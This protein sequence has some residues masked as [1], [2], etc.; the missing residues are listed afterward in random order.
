MENSY[1]EADCSQEEQTDRMSWL[2]GGTGLSPFEKFIRLELFSKSR[3]TS[4]GF[5]SS[6][7]NYKSPV[8]DAEGVH[9]ASTTVFSVGRGGLFMYLL[10]S[11][12]VYLSVCVYLFGLGALTIL[13]FLFGSI[14]EAVI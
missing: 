1:V 8:V 13:S 11:V 6:C 9:T 5:C 10:I 7:G 3:W 4:G 12:S 2:D 14:P